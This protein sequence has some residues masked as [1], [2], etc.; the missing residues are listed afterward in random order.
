MVISALNFYFW[1]TT[2]HDSQFKKLLIYLLP[3]LNAAPQF[4]LCLKQAVLAPVSLHITLIIMLLI[5]ILIF[6]V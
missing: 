3:V 5:K 1:T 6:T 4:S 2:V